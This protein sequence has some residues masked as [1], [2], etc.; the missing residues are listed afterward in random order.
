MLAIHKIEISSIAD[1]VLVI[2]TSLAGMNADR[3]VTE[4]NKRRKSAHSS[5]I[6]SVIINLQKTPLDASCALRIFADADKAME[7]LAR[8]YRW[9]AVVLRR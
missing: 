3:V 7:M 1:L 9:I 8:S 5:A 4:C 6:G 2:G